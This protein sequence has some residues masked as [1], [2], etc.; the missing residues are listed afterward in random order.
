MIRPTP[1]R[2]YEIKSNKSEYI[3]ET[4]EEAKRFIVQSIPRERGF[5]IDGD[6][7]KVVLQFDRGVIVDDNPSISVEDVPDPSPAWDRWDRIKTGAV[8]IGI[9]VLVTIGNLVCNAIESCDPS[10]PPSLGGC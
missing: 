2:R 1:H 7:N 8:L 3:L 10:A 9:L 6:E 4:L 5:I